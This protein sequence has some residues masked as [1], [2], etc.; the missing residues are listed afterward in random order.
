MATSNIEKNKKAARAAIKKVYPG[1]S[2]MA[3]NGLMVNLGIEGNFDSDNLKE[4]KYTYNRIRSKKDGAW[5]TMNKNLVSWAKK[6]N[7]GETKEGKFIIDEKK[8]KKAFNKLNRQQRLGVQY[9]G[10]S[11]AKYAGGY[12]AL[13]FTSRGGAYGD[14]DFEGKV[15]KV[16][17]EMN[18][19]G[20][21][22]SFI[23]KMS[24]DYAFGTEATLLMKKN[25]GMTEEK[26]NKAGTA[27]RIRAG[28]IDKEK[29]GWGI[30]PGEPWELKDNEGR[31]SRHERIAKDFGQDADSIK[32]IQQAMVDAGVKD[33]DGNEL[34][35]DGDWGDNSEYAFQ[36]FSTNETYA[37]DYKEYQRKA[38]SEEEGDVL[39]EGDE[40]VEYGPDNPDP[41]TGTLNTAEDMVLNEYGD[42]VS[43]DSAEGKRL[44]GKIQVRTKQEEDVDPITGEVIQEEAVTGEFEELG[45][46]S[47]RVYD[48]ETEEQYLV[49]VDFDE[50]EFGNIT[51]K[52][53][54]YNK[55]GENI[56]DTNKELVES[57]TAEVVDKALSGENKFQKEGD[58]YYSTQTGDLR[59]DRGRFAIYD[60]PLV[61][62]DV[63]E[64]KYIVKEDL[65]EN[66]SE[67]VNKLV[68]EKNEERLRQE[69]QQE[70]ESKER[71]RE[72]AMT[73]NVGREHLANLEKELEGLEKRYSTHN[74]ETASYYDKR[75]YKKLKKQIDKLKYE[76]EKTKGNIQ[77][78]EE[79]TKLSIAVSNEKTAKQKLAQIQKDLENDP[80]SHTQEEVDQAKLE[81]DA[82]VKTVYDLTD[83]DY[84]ELPY[85][86]DSAL[87]EQQQAKEQEIIVEPKAATVIGAEGEQEGEGEQEQEVVVSPEVTVTADR[88]EDEGEGI[89]EDPNKKAKWFQ[90]ATGVSSLISGV[91][92]GVGLSAALKNPE[93][94]DM[95]KLSQ[96][97][98]EHLRQSRELA[99]QGFSPME[100]AKI[101][102]DIDK[103]YKTGIDNIVRGTAGNRARFLAMSGALDANRSSALLDFAAKD[104]EMARSN[105][106]EYGELLKY[107]ETFEA[108][109]SLSLRSEDLQMQLENKKAGAE[110]AKNAF[111][112]I[113]DNVNNSRLNSLRETYMEKL[114]NDMS[115]DLYQGSDDH[116]Q[117]RA[118]DNLLETNEE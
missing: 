7:Y 33:E 104:S 45:D 36:Q 15:K 70:I 107:K 26:L 42:F 32:A 111:S 66:K 59:E 67:T 99:N 106:K 105:R 57:L 48:N 30:N 62:Y 52:V 34:A 71:L 10:D 8:A 61:T 113:M 18:Y 116:E 19:K 73:D 29:E 101:R 38:T 25:E 63:N 94:K 24:S 35:V 11:T 31:M 78:T 91:L 27:K 90:G 74:P 49:S 6:N 16:M 44:T 2:D 65:P 69:Q 17:K 110:L 89:T 28:I 51:K 64:D 12:G 84:V 1:I 46:Y 96:A 81:V 93:P 60:K 118:V 82:A 13:Q 50:D 76:I 5:K 37:V 20:T 87:I 77:E 79:R 86:S 47:T 117:N 85:D 41:M 3:L 83:T 97:F 53:S 9:H 21:F 100:E 54:I 88:V 95:P 40:D 80:D 68:K 109:K 103:A 72:D 112:E 39:A 23:K 115:S 108:N 56:T 75:Q 114:I 102:T 98:E 58:V 92:G 4:G 55:D 22:D 14:Y 43:V